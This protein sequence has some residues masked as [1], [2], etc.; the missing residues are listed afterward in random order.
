MSDFAK[1]DSAIKFG[2]GRYRQEQGLLEKLGEEIARFGTRLLIIAGNHSW[3]AVEARLVPSLEAANIVWDLVIWEEA[4][5]ELAARKLAERAHSFHADEVVG[6]GGGKNMDLAKATGEVAGLGVITI[7]TSIAQCAPFA[8]TSV[9]YTPEGKKD[10]TWRYEHEIDGCYMD[11]DVIAGCPSRYLAAGVLDAM[12]KKIEILNGRPSLLLEKTDIDL[13]YAYKFA[14]DTYA[15]LE[16]RAQ[17]AMDAS[18][19]GIV[20]KALADIAF[21]NVAAT[22]VISNTTRGYNQTQLAH[23]F[24]DCARTLFTDEV[25]S[26]VHG[27]IVAVGLFLQ[28]HF[29][30]LDCEEERLR[31]LLKAWGMPDTL[32]KLG[33]DATKENLEA[34]EEYIVSSRHYNS[35]DPADRALLRESISRMA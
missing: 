12:A 29:N 31:E 8:C 14:C 17:E 7:P 33:I 30:G 4:C 23:V 10:V 16:D 18:R 32:A 20:N 25:A 2:A 35:T 26:C 28:L 13:Y 24:Y 6:I 11:L 34:I 22:G 15:V 9:M 21:T 3:A 19:A 27:E 5:S 1:K